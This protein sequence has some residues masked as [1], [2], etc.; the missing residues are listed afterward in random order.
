MALRVFNSEKS[1]DFFAGL[2]KG[3]H[4]VICP[5][6]SKAFPLE[7]IVAHVLT[8]VKKEPALAEAKPSGA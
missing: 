3:I 7:D 2:Y 8:H 1:K 4:L 5:K 6:C